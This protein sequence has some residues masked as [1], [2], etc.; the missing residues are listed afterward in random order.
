[1]PPLYSSQQEA[2]IASSH[3]QRKAGNDRAEINVPSFVTQAARP[4]GNGEPISASSKYEVKSGAGQS[5]DSNWPAPGS[6]ACGRMSP[7][8]VAK[9]LRAGSLAKGRKKTLVLDLDE[10]LIHSEF[11]P[12]RADMYV[13]MTMD[14]VDYTAYVMKRPGC[15]EF[16]R[17]ATQLFDVVVWTASLECYAGGVIDQLEKLSGCG[18]LPR[19]YRESCT[20]LNGSYVK[21]LSKLRAPLADVVIIDNSPHVA[22]LNRRNLVHI[23]NFYEDKSDRHLYDLLPWLDTLAGAATAF[24]AISSR[25][26]K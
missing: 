12:R 6:S 7:R 25:H 18:R 11:N 23:E 2:G 14:G 4:S 17:K 21:D 5:W 26:S 3:G 19:M 16:L 20:K 1:M 8:A 24:D 9:P 22:A 10:T 13:P 15:E